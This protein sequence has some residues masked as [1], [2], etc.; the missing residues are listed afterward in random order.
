L[1]ELFL[2]R[3]LLDFAARVANKLSIHR[4]VTADKPDAN[5]NTEDMYDIDEV[6]K[7]ANHASLEHTNPFGKYLGSI[8]ETGGKLE[9]A[10][11]K[12]TDL[13]DL[14]ARQNKQMEQ[15]LMQMQNLMSQARQQPP[16]QLYS[17]GQAP[18]QNHLAPT[19]TNDG[20]C[21]YC[22]RPHRVAQC[23]D[24]FMHLDMG[25]IKKI[26]RMLRFPDG[27]RI[28]RDPTGVKCMKEVVEA[29]QKGIIPTSKIQDKAALFQANKMVAAL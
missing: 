16:L 12:L 23:E 26:D 29:M 3:L 20:N 21:F 4:L 10:V 14:Q 27:G 28:Q 18:T 25:W 13:I 9:E 11:A 24:V 5:R 15:R 1:V 2:E 7:M 8:Q 22:C 17:Q 19:Y 6:M